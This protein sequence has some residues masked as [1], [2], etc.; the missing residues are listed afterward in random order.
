MAGKKISTIPEPPR[1][2]D[3]A[4]RSFMAAVKEAI[5]V[6]LGRRGDPLEEGVTRRELVE[7]GIA[8]IAQGP[9]GMGSGSLVVPRPGN[10][11]EASITPPMP[12]NLYAIGV[13][14]GISLSWER[15]ADQYNV[16]AY[17][18]IWRSQTD[19]IA[20]RVM[21]GSSRGSSYFD[22][23]ME[24]G[25]RVY[26][27]WVRFVSSYD[28]RGP[29]AGPVGA[30]KER[31]TRKLLEEL[32]GAIDQSVLH[33]SLST[34]IEEFGQ[35]IIANAQSILE[36]AQARGEAV[37][38][39]MS[40]IEAI[41]GPTGSLAAVRDL[42][43]AEFDGAIATVN[44]SISALTSPGGAVTNLV[45]AAAVASGSALAAY[46]SEVELV[47][48]EG[49]TLATAVESLSTSVEGVTTAVQSQATIVQG[50]SAQFTLKLDV[51][52]YVAGY[53]LYNDGATSDFAVAADR[54]W[55]APPGSTGQIKPFVVQADPLDGE[56]K[57]FINSAVIR[58]ASI[59]EGKLGP[60]TFGKLVDGDG[61]P[62]TTLSGKLLADNIDVENISI[63]D[64]NISGVLKS[65]AEA[66]PGGPPLW[67]LD[68]A[69]GFAMN[70]A[71]NGGRMEIRDN[72][73]KVFDQNGVLR[74]QLGDLTV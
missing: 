36:E 48:G 3:A 26:Y 62:V 39:V 72:V 43:I 63:T 74:V 61:M 14:G 60:I 29:F 34:R 44:S 31:D 53:G 45:D 71:T 58:D 57:V 7:A 65:S 52:G 59:Q 70:S 41:T 11:A 67:S 64:G 22:R 49:G 30:R 6:R 21:L 17:A 16:H 4:T 20:D 18:E 1:T 32:S 15:P 9:G 2:A 33:Q 46:K 28:K 37:A 23:I 19:D 69:G 42:L 8:D 40:E 12:S 47:I 27:Y 50:L 56:Q 54:F 55:I 25:E 68:K 5:E 66:W 73:I 51:D 38:D 24:T 10:S 35:D 13:F